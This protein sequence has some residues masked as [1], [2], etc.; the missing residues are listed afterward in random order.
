MF[1]PDFDYKKS[2][3]LQET[4]QRDRAGL[5]FDLNLRILTNQ[6][7]QLRTQSQSPRFSAKFFRFR[8]STWYPCKKNK[9]LNSKPK[10]NLRALNW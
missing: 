7:T 2:A 9:T 3:G 5:I 6:P 8:K 1:L 10:A 4:R